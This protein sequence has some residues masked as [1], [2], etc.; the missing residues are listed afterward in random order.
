MILR[1]KCHSSDFKRCPSQAPK[2]WGEQGVAWRRSKW[3]KRADQ[4]EFSSSNPGALQTIRGGNKKTKNI[5]NHACISHHT[6]RHASCIVQHQIISCIFASFSY[7][8]SH[9]WPIR[10][11]NCQIALCLFPSK[12]GT[13]LTSYKQSLVPA[14]HPLSTCLVPFHFSVFSC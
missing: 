3:Q 6:S 13:C 2:T 7:S 8:H 14:W 5:K 10:P 1:S 9:D 12:P 11:N 4:Q